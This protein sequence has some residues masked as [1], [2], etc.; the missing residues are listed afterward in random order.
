MIAF[1]LKT[2]FLQFIEILKNNASQTALLCH[3]FDF[4]NMFLA[5]KDDF[6]KIMCYNKTSIIFQKMPFFR[7]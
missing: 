5:L 7:K 4:V 1:Y 2:I 6:L 3:V